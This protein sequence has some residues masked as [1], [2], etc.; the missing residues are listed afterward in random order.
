[1]TREMHFN[2]DSTISVAFID[3]LRTP[4]PRTTGNED[5][6]RIEHDLITEGT[7]L[8]NPAEPVH[9]STIPEAVRTVIADLD[10]VDD[11]KAFIERE[12]EH[13]PRKYVMGLVNQRIDA[14]READGDA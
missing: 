8:G 11:T 3:H 14:I 2:P 12:R 7:P 4:G 1:M 13:G 6:L 10:T 5:I 9:E